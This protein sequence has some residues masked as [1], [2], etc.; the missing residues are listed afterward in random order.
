MPRRLA[1]KKTNHPSFACS[2][3]STTTKNM[4]V[5][6]AEKKMIQPEGVV[7]Q[8]KYNPH[9]RSRFNQSLFNWAISFSAVILAAQSLKS[10]KQRQKVDR[11]LQESEAISLER[12]K[13]L[14]SLVLEPKTLEPMTQRIV[15]E[16]LHKDQEVMATKERT[17]GWLGWL[18]SS[19]SKQHGIKHDAD[20]LSESAIVSK[21]L[22]EEMFRLI[23]EKAFDEAQREAFMAKNNLTSS[24][25]AAAGDAGENELKYLDPE[26]LMVGGAVAAA[27]DLAAPTMGPAA[28]K[29][30]KAFTM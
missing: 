6:N 24:T 11:Q 23:G 20:A 21:I 1:E 14:Q 10:S 28:E 22:L 8:I 9:F 3:S 2:F 12:L 25:A 30:K 26:K 15:A 17:S 16:L 27:E 4:A 19:T 5:E 13:L 7:E 29:R 18:G